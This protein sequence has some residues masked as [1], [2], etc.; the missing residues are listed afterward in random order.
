MR[1]SRAAERNREGV[2]FRVGSHVGRDSAWFSGSLVLWPGT[3][4]QPAGQRPQLGCV[5]CDDARCILPD[6]VS[7]PAARLLLHPPLAVSHP[8]T[9]PLERGCDGT[10]LEPARLS[11][12]PG[13]IGTQGCVV[14]CMCS[15]LV[16]MCGAFLESCSSI[17]RRSLSFH[18][19][20][21]ADDGIFHA[22][23]RNGSS[24][25]RDPRPH[26][27]PTSHE[28]LRAGPRPLQACS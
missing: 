26:G 19:A 6:T 8:C 24:Q 25:K 12:V 2:A 22:N 20:S 17:L 3:A 16:G 21:A 18:C 4:A 15:V 9:H 13:K 1:A 11:T 10:G 23:K 28:K 27:R 14:P 5:L 7:S